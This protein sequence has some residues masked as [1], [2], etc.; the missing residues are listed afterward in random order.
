LIWRL[1]TNPQSKALFPNWEQIAEAIIAELH[2]ARARF[3]DDADFERLIADLKHESEV[4]AD[5][6]RVTKPP[7]HWTDIK[8]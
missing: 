2:T 4:F 6:D 3:Q 1:F 8:R 7:A 5:Y